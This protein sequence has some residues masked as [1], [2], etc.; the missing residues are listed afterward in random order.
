MAKIILMSQFPLPYAHIG[1]WTTLYRNYLTQQHLIDTI[2][3]EKPH[4]FFE[5]VQ[6]EIVAHNF[7]TRL[8]C[9]ISGNRYKHYINALSKL[10]DPNEKYIIQV[11]DNS[12]LAK[13]VQKY[14]DQ[15]QLRKH[16]YLQYFFHGHSPVGSGFNVRFYERTDEMVVLTKSA[17][18]TFKRE[19]NIL[20]P[21]FSVLH[22]GIDTGKFFP[23][24][25]AE[26]NKLKEQQGFAG[27]K[28]FLWCSQDRPKKGLH[29]VLDAWKKFFET[30]QNIALIVIGCEPKTPQA[31]VFYLG[32][33]QNDV[34]PHYYQMS[35]AF[36]FST[37]C[38]EGFGMSLIEAMHCGCY[39]IASAM[40]GVPEVLQFG[41]LGKLIENP[42]FVNEWITAM[43]EF[44]QGNGIS[45]QLPADLY[46]ASQWNL[47]MNRIIENAQ[48]SMET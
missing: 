12:G 28:I 6:Y 23:V 40:G 19:S 5:N 1:S 14:I 18:D 39:A 7:H 17:Y 38:Q 48:K 29:I 32:R 27:K 46:T 8:Q 34:L 13:A 44:M 3:C 16:C 24:S 4:Y 2:V 26:K 35:D 36:L 21:R 31:G 11:V 37:L 9:K 47:E 43:T 25:V 41:K 30:Q 33:I 20:P 10:I 45:Y 22:N 42:H 15:K